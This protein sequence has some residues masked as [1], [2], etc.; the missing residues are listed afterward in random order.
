MEILR[1]RYFIWMTNFE[2]I[3]H[4]FLDGDLFPIALKSTFNVPMIDL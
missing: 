1:P 4:R 2:L 3:L